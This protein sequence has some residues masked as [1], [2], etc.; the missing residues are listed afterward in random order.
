MESRMKTSAPLIKKSAR[1]I[2]YP[3]MQNETHKRHK[4]STAASQKFLTPPSQVRIPSGSLASSPTSAHLLLLDARFKQNIYE[5]TKLIL[6]SLSE[7]HRKTLGYLNTL[8]YFN[9][10]GHPNTLGYLKHLVSQ[11]RKIRAISWCEL[12]FNTLRQFTLY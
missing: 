12:F 8:V 10:L 6:I 7:P 5:Y 2:K 9:T 4:K 1:V 11:W 3:Q